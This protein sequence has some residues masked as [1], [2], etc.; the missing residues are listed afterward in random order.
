MTFLLQTHDDFTNRG[1]ISQLETSGDLITQEYVLKKYGA[2]YFCV[3][4]NSPEMHTIWKGWIGESKSK[5][6]P[7]SRQTMEILSL[8]NNTD[9]LA[10]GEIVLGVGE[11]LG[12]ALTGSSLADHGIRL[13]RAEAILHVY[14]TS[15]PIS[16]LCP[17]CQ[18][19]LNDILDDYCG[20]CGAKT[21][22][23]P[24]LQADPSGR[25][26]PNCFYPAKTEQNFCNHCGKTL[27]AW[28][29]NGL[30]ARIAPFHPLRLP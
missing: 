22:W 7:P 13:N 24:L 11:V 6:D 30:G 21:D 28:S 15:N 1:P 18:H 8:K 14:N 20:N 4:D 25:S 16:V 3:K 23:T 10:L 17:G 2:G 9:N 29:P 19:T 5:N 26:C 27:P 12:F